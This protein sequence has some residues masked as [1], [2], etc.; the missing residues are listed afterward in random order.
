MNPASEKNPADR[1]GIGLSLATQKFEPGPIENQPWGVTF[2][3]RDPDDRR[4]EVKQ[5]NRVLV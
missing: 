3:V 4:V 2:I 1:C 5:E